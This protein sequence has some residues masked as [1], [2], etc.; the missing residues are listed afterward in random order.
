MLTKESFHQIYGGLDDYMDYLAIIQA[1]MG[2]T[3]LPN[4]VLL[5]LHGKTVLEH[6]I[7]RVKKSKYID[8]VI[9]ATTIEEKDLAIVKLCS[10]LN[11][12]VYCGSVDDVLDRY[13]QAAKLFKPKNV[14]RI[15]ADCP[16]MDPGVI[17]SVVK[18][19]EIN[20]CD[21]TS[22]VIEETFPDGEDV[23]VIKYNTL[24]EAWED[25]K[26]A[27]EREHVTLYIRNNSKYSKHSVISKINYGDK[28]WTLDTEDDY[29][30]ISKIYD[31]LYPV[32]QLFSMKEVLELLEKCPELEYINNKIIRNEGLIKS[33]KNDYIMEE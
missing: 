10:E 4:K 17:D 31:D 28:R 27:S 9:V 5:D 24:N 22:N 19:H 14:V 6:V 1:R 29:R 13:Y 33:L 11:T 16:L 18:A 21:Y 30:F 12:Q 20:L 3:R 2:S 15:T 32:N 8:K 7:N 23:E 25:S 26:L